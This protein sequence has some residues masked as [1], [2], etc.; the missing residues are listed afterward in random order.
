MSKLEDVKKILGRHTFWVLHEA[1]ENDLTYERFDQEDTAKEICQLDPK[2]PDNPDGHEPQFEYC[3]QVPLGGCPLNCEADMSECTALHPQKSDGEI[4]PNCGDKP[5]VEPKPDAGRLLT[6]EERKP[7][8]H[9]IIDKFRSYGRTQ[10]DIDGLL[11]AQLLKV[12]KW[13]DEV[14]MEHGMRKRRRCDKCWQS[15]LQ[16]NLTPEQIKEIEL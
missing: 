4:C 5:G 1:L 7:F 13:G 2:S 6:E 15:F 10:W 11:K 3:S 9:Q 12:V 8:H 14:C 16:K